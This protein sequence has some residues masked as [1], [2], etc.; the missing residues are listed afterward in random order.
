MTNTVGGA[1]GKRLS[2]GARLVYAFDA[3]AEVLLLIEAA[4]APDQAVQHESL[5][6]TPDVAI[7]RSQDPETGE[8]LHH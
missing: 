1:S 4:C 8:R 2:V 5:I 6:I 3:P 7:S